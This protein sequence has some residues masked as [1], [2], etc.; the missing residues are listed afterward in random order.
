MNAKEVPEGYRLVDVVAKKT[1][2]D[3]RTLA[4]PADWDDDMIEDEFFDQVDDWFYDDCDDD[5]VS[6]SVLPAR[7][8]RPDLVLDENGAADAVLP[9]RPPAA[10]EWGTVNGRRFATNGHILVFE[11]CPQGLAREWIGDGDEHYRKLSTIDPTAV[12]PACRPEVQLDLTNWI[13]G[14]LEGSRI[15]WAADG[16]QVLMGA[17]TVH[18]LELGLDALQSQPPLGPVSLWRGDVLLAIAMPNRL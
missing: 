13:R 12:L 4:V 7:S 15:Y 1:L 5:G 9:L 18:L 14:D 3:R 6:F 2:S 8:A 10:D 16:Q 11:D 17:D